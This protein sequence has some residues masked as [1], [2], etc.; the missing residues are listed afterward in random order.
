VSNTASALSNMLTKNIR[1]ERHKQ[2]QSSECASLRQPASKILPATVNEP[3]V[4]AA[5]SNR[6]IHAGM[7]VPFTNVATDP[8]LPDNMPSFSLDP[9]APDK[10]MV[11]PVSG[12]FGWQTDAL[13]AGTTHPVTVR[14]T[15]DGNAPLSGTQSFNIT[16]SAPP[17]LQVV[18]VPGEE[19]VLR[20]S[21][22]PGT[23]YRVQHKDDL[24]A[25]AWT[26][27]V[28]DLVAHGESFSQTNAVGVG[29]R[30]F[31]VEI[32]P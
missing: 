14:V 28:P 11:Q 21:S 19:F 30:F 8:D 12:I 27:T 18:P 10:A 25:A 3:P 26:D 22:I 2:K 7:L 1:P 32:L 24:A 15:D 29:Q 17:S 13:D 16:V 20:W 6:T 5:L 9:R 31:R 23:R 4:L